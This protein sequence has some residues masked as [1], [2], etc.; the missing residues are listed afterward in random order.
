MMP[1]AGAWM[2][3]PWTGA[4]TAVVGGK[5]LVPGRSIYGVLPRILPGR[6][7]STYPSGFS[8]VLPNEGRNK[9]HAVRQPT[10]KLS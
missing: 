5:R 6:T 4:E 10:R 2:G 9:T 7:P 1:E 8:P 3:L